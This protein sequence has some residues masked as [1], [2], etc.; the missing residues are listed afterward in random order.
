MTF[1]GNRSYIFGVTIFAHLSVPLSA[2][3]P[4]AL[5]IAESPE[6]DMNVAENWSPEAVPSGVIQVVF[7]SSIENVDLSPTQSDDNFSVCSILFS[8]SASPFTIHFNNHEVA[9]NG[10]GITGVQTNAT[11]NATNTDNS[12]GL[13]NQFSFNRNDNSSSGS[14][15][16]NI[17]NTGSLLSNSSSVTLGSMENQFFVQGPF[18]MLDG[19]SLTLTNIGSDSSHG[20]GGNQISFITAYQVQINNTNSVEDNV[21]VSI[22]NVGTYIGSN[23]TTGNVIGFVFSGQYS[24]ADTFFAGDALDFS[25]TNRGVNSGT[26][27]GA[28]SIGLVGSSQVSFGSVCDLGDSSTITIS[29][30]GEN[31]GGSGGLGSNALYV[32][33][34]YEHQLYVHTQFVAGDDFSLTATNVG[35]DSGS[36]SGQTY[37]GYIASLGSDGDQV[38]FNNS[39]IV[40]KDATFITENSGTCSG[41]KTGSVTSVG[42]LNSG[43]MK[44]SGEFQADDFLNFSITNSGTD[45]SHSI[46]ANSVGIVSLSQ[47]L[48]GSSLVTQDN[49]TISVSNQG[50]FSGNAASPTNYVGVVGSAQFKVVS[51]FE[52]G[53]AFYLHIENIGEDTGSGVGNNLIGS[54]GAQQVYFESSCTLGDDANIV[55]SNTGVNSNES[56]A[57]QTGYV[58]FSQLAVD[59]NF[60]AGDNLNIAITNS[61][62]NTGNEINYVGYVSGS[63]ALFNGTVTLG[64]GSVISTTNNG[65]VE[66]TQISFNEGFTV[67]SGKVTIQVINE[68]RLISDIGFFIQ[69]A[70]SGGNANIILKD[71]TLDIETTLPTFTIGELNGDSSSIVKSIP[72]IIINTDSSTNALF[73]GVIQDHLDTPLILTKQ[74]PGVQTL[75]GINTYTGLT[76]I[77]EGV[78]SITGSVAGDLVVNSGGTLKGAGTIGGETTIEN[79]ATLS[80]GNSIGTINLGSLV[81]NPGSTTVI[82]IDPT[83]S[84]SVNVTESALVDGVLKIVQDPGLYPRQGSYL[85][86]SADSVSGVF[87]SVN[88]FPGFT[89]DLSYPGNGVYLNYVLAI[90]TQGLSG[91]SLKVANYLNANAPSSNAFMSLSALSGDP[92]SQALESIS[93]SRNAFGTYITEQIAFSLSNLISAHMDGLRISLQKSSEDHF[94]ST[95]TAD[96]SN[97]L[98]ADKSPENK[99]SVW[100]SGFGEF[101][102]QDASSQNPSF[103]FIS[104]AALAGIDYQG[105]NR[106]VVGGGLGYAHTHYYE[107]NH[108]G[109]G[110]INY[111]FVSL[112]SNHFISNFYFSPAILGI[113]NQIDN[114]RSISFSGF[115]ENA[116]ANIFA[117]Q[118]IPHLEVGYDAKFSWGNISPFTSADLAI[119]WQR[120]YQE[121]GAS[122]F[123]AKQK[124][125]NSS[126]VR[127]ETG[128]KFCEKWE[129]N[130]GALVLREKVSYVFE[131]PYG[132]GTVNSSFVG[133]PGAFTVTALNQNLNLGIVGLN[134]LVVIGKTKPVQ[135]NFGYEGE[136][137]S[138]YWSNELMFTISKGF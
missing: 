23:G 35:V 33:G 75:S 95:L 66:G 72:S 70:N 31:S 5:W 42:Q 22:S 49:A 101:A 30:Y 114:V 83:A 37:V 16:I 133:M 136:L 108:A 129:K 50:N 65:T 63:Q 24:N 46:N 123:N 36:G 118:F 45:S 130:W 40:G 135:L 57:N 51:S 12:T 60:I 116:H 61:A 58:N 126:M 86:L 137:G 48:F 117:W 91:N 17:V 113:F 121:H 90:P 13:G 99:F 106:S 56:T 92:L 53:N 107:D 84:S 25:V 39:C 79:G 64:D 105:E 76:S 4:L 134:L 93:P 43:Q 88:T 120:G 77:Q 44:F 97:R 18:S 74:G 27:A 102:H 59:G 110:N 10:T 67:S 7:D 11:M 132:T 128:L 71:V 54:V 20:D 38:M 85:I 8:N 119:S 80:P 100:V 82:E 55:I 32:G 89:F 127:S 87:S 21:S 52:S 29:N 112:Y 34:V 6:H 41:S 73:S 19:G 111:Y 1:F 124:A 2:I 9:L 69:G 68:G 98:I 138:N 47:L 103:N 122:P 131:K 94:T 26:S 104:E 14:A 96:N 62:T 125:N 109:H 3:T 78:L 115:S 15:A 28:S 81:L